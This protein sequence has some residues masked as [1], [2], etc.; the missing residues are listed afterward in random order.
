MLYPSPWKTGPP[1]PCLVTVLWRPWARP[2]A[3][4]EI[5][6][7]TSILSFEKTLEPK[8]APK[9]GACIKLLEALATSQGWRWLQ[10]SSAPLERNV[11]NGKMGASNESIATNLYHDSLFFFQKIIIP[12]LS[13]YHYKKL[14]CEQSLVAC[15]E[16]APRQQSTSPHGSLLRLK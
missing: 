7:L 8:W 1:P 14:R 5:R 12:S 10:V 15:R 11:S 3:R 9:T 4:L 16:D 6:D 2:A 13:C